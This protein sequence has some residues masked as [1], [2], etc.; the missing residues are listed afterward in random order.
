MAERSKRTGVNADR[1]VLE[2]AKIAFVNPADFIDMNTLTIKDSAS[3]DDLAT[4]SSVKVKTFPTRSGD[5]AIEKEIRTYDK[6]RALELL[7]KHL[8]MFTDKVKLEAPIPVVIYGDLDLE[9]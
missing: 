8:G 7:G 3:D 6:I 4:I 9:D 5:V 1:V 2:L